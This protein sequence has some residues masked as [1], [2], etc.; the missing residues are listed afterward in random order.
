MTD[1]PPIP[2]QVGSPET[3]FLAAAEEG[4]RRVGVIV[5]HG[6]G[7]QLPFETLGLVAAALRRWEEARRPGAAPLPVTTRI[8]DLPGSEE[9]ASETDRST[10]R[11]LPRVEIPV[12]GDDGREHHVHLYEAYWAPLTEG[13]VTSAD[14]VRFM[15]GAGWRGIWGART[16]TFERLVFGR[17]HAF[18][19]TPFWLVLLFGAAIVVFVSLLLINASVVAAA[20]GRFATRPGVGWPS[21]ELLADLAID[22]ALFLGPALLAGVVAGH[23]HWRHD[24]AK[25]ASRAWRPARLWL[26]CAWISV[27]A[28]LA[29]TVAVA[30]LI[31][32]Q[33]VW[34]QTDT[35]GQAWWAAQPGALGGVWPLAAG[36][37]ERG[38]VLLEMAFWLG[39]YW[40]AVQARGFFVQYLGDVAAY[41]SSHELNRF[42]ELREKI[43]EISIEVAR[44]VYGARDETTRAPA[45]DSLVVVGH[46]LGAVVAYDTFNALV[47]LDDLAGGALSV[48]ART[49]LLLT[50]GAP[51]NKTAF[52][53]RTQ[54]TGHDDVREALAAAKQP[55]ITSYANRPRRWI[56]VYSRADWI[57]GTVD[58]YDL[59]VDADAPDRPDPGR[60][61]ENVSDPEALT[62]LLAHTEYWAN[63]LFTERLHAAV[64]ASGVRG[65]AGSR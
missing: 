15:F 53:F 9:P 21:A 47:N 22:V 43:K 49:E 2:A 16:G 10:R 6:M 4:P 31:V 19:L 36:V 46:S 8:V 28:A 39:A 58:Y 17:W 37:R 54:S 12:L 50:F 57:S 64:R 7:Q 18:G 52:V 45:Y 24:V 56:N 25:R 5:C 44:T 55:L 61:V 1:T 20:A 3:G 42:H 65:A 59:P 38:G 32:V 34:Y 29:T 60:R 40:L 51:L 26:L 14:V 30:V 27:V 62:P 23:M 63:D 35:T 41:V 11:G 13:Q 48:V 33:L